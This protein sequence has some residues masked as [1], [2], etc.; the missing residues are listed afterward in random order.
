METY[1]IGW[2]PDR[3]WCWYQAFGGI[4]EHAGKIGQFNMSSELLQALI[5]PPTSA[6]EPRN[7]RTA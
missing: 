5:R 1:R 6:P 2:S 7:A 3:L 4:A